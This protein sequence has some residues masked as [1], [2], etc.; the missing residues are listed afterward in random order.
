MQYSLTLSA[1]PPPPV[2]LSS[3]TRNYLHIS[4]IKNILPG[5]TIPGSSGISYNLKKGFLNICVNIL[6]KRCDF[7]LAQLKTNEVG[8]ALS[9]N[10]LPSQKSWIRLHPTFQ[11]AWHMH[12]FLSSSFSVTVHQMVKV[13][14][15]AKSVH[16]YLNRLI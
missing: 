6:A 15:V 10:G 13:A 14:R 4:L 3:S 12:F 16:I 5:V 11:L 2:Y 1:P 8:R 7:S 9:L